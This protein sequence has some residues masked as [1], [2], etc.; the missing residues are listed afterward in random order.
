MTAEYFLN[1]DGEARRLGTKMTVRLKPGDV[2]SYRTCGGGGYGKPL[3]RDPALVVDD[4][5]NGKVSLERAR[6]VYGVE[7]DSTTWTYDPHATAYLRSS[8]KGARKKT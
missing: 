7:V 8:P 5:R 6:T 2:V 3:E 1:P 4:V